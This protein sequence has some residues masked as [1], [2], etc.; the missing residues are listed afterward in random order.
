[1]LADRSVAE[2]RVVG[3][4]SPLRDGQAQ[5]FALVQALP[6]PVQTPTGTPAPNTMMPRQG[7]IR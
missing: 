7:S 5:G 1:V 3:E 6:E 4:P 2:I